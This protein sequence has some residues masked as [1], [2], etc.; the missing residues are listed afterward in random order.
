MN[1][2]KSKRLYSAPA[3]LFA[4]ATLNALSDY[5]LAWLFAGS[6]KGNDP[7]SGKP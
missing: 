3:L 6:G 5:F 1:L 7:G 4:A 2:L